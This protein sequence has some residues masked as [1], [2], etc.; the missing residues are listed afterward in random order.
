MY[1]YQPIYHLHTDIYLLKIFSV[2]QIFPIKFIV[3]H[4][5][6][7]NQGDKWCKLMYLDI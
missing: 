4:L 3:S 6:V 7:E 5:F 1:Y 2:V